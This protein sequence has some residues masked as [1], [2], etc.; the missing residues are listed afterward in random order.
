M[1]TNTKPANRFHR[2][3]SAIISCLG[4]MIA[5]GTLASCGTGSSSMSTST[6]VALLSEYR[7]K[8]WHDA[9]GQSHKEVR[10][11]RP[12]HSSDG[13]WEI[14]ENPL[15]NYEFP[16][17]GGMPDEAMIAEVMRTMSS[18]A[19][20]GPMRKS[21]DAMAFYSDVAMTTK[22]TSTLLLEPDESAPVSGSGTSGEGFWNGQASR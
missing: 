18:D 9:P 14:S 6:P 22:L 12:H 16:S 15:T 1:K 7:I 20:K 10:V 17:V 11:E 4:P 2:P 3:L 21:D 8:S 19:P 13:T 5:T